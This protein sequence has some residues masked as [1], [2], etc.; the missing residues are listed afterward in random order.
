M[1]HISEFIRD[2]GY[3][4]QELLP[5]YKKSA[6]KILARSEVPSQYGHTIGTVWDVSFETLSVESRVLLWILAFFDPDNIPEWILSN[7]RARITESGMQFLF[8]EFE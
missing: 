8:D 3:S 1:V 2:R 4:Y 7:T 6:E 5:A